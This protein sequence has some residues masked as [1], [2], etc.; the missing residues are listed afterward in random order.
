MV[1]APLLMIAGPRPCLL[2]PP[3]LSQGPLASLKPQPGS[4]CLSPAGVCGSTPGYAE[5]TLLEG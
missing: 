5:L 3:S 1:T 2:P 4:I